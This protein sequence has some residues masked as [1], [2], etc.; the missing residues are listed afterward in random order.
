[1]RFRRL[2]VQVGEKMSLQN[3]REKLLGLTEKEG[4]ISPI[5][6]IGILGMVLILLSSFWD[7]TD[8]GGKVDSGGEDTSV[9]EYTTQLEERLYDIVKTIDGVGKTKVMITVESSPEYIYALEEKITSDL[10]EETQENTGEKRQQKT[11][12]ENG[13]IMVESPGGQEQALIRKRV[14]P[15][16][17]GALIVCEGADSP[18]VEQRVVEAVTTALGIPSTRVC[19]TKI[20]Q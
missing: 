5:F 8:T 3:L 10:S 4:K 17:K 20:S 13:Y 16:I 1:M 11:T 15:Q 7:F 19:V 12:S 6:W 9:L 18:Q 2:K 14:E